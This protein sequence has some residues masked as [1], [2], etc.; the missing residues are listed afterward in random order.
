VDEVIIYAVNDGAVMGA[1]EKDQGVPGLI[2]M[3]GDP[4][5]DLTNALGLVLD[6]PG[7]MSVLGNPRCQRF[8]MLIEDGVIKTINVA[9]ADDDPAGDARPEVSMVEKM[10]EDLGGSTFKGTAAAKQAPP[11]KITDPAK[12]VGDAMKKKG[13]SVFAKT[14]CPYCQTALKI[15]E[16]E[17]ADMT[18][19]Q[20][21]LFQEPANGPVQQELNKISG[22]MSVPQ[23]FVDGKFIGGA[24]DIEKLKEAG[25]LKDAL[26]GA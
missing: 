22:T 8:S 13:I 24:S 15:M 1:W 19:Y 9:A 25:T 10:L 7:P 21:D 26:K 23:I 3:M 12:F 16:G 6:H 11:D 4:C 18:V 20:L 17:N 2:N 14:Y 5:S